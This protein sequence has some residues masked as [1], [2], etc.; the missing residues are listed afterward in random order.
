M[1]PKSYDFHWRSSDYAVTHMC[2]ENSNVEGRSPNVV[3]VIFHSI[4]NYSSRKEF[5]PSGS[6]FFP[7]REVHILKRDAVDENH[8]LI[9]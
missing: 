7:V 8:C 1:E 3:K 5:A 6:K 4:R 9:Q 2:N